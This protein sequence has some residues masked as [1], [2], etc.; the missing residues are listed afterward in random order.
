MID[1]SYL[2]FESARLFQ[3]RGMAKW[4]GFF[5]SEHTHAL[6]KDR[7]PSCPMT[8]L[9]SQEQLLEVCIRLYQAN[10]EADFLVRTEQDPKTYTGKIRGLSSD[11]ISLETA[12]GFRLLPVHEIL[13]ISPPADAS[14]NSRG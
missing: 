3:D 4:M 11:G 12:S 9:L 13:S 2:P 8:P 5:L 7:L 6:E 10:Q 14:E 1:R